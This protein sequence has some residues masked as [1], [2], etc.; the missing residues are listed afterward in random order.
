MDTSLELKQMD[1]ETQK[2]ITLWLE[3]DY[4][5]ET[6]EAIRHLLK[7]NPQE[8]VDAFYKT[9]TFGTG[10]MR[11]IMGV[12]TNRMNLYTIRT[13]TQGLANYILQQEAGEKFHSVFIGYDS[14]HHSKEFAEEAAKVLAANNIH[15]FLYRDLRPT[16]LISF[17]CRFKK[18]TAGIMITA[19]HNTPEYNGYKVYWSDGGQVLPPHDIGIVEEV[20]KILSLSQVHIVDTLESPLINLIEE[21]VDDAYL[22]SI[23]TLQFYPQENKTR[24]QEL[25]IIYTSLHGTGITLV[26]RALRM[27]GF[28]KF[29][30]VDPQ[31]IPDGDFPTAHYP[32]PEEKEALSLG[33]SVLA[34][35]KAD[36]LIATDPDCD[37]VGV[38]VHHQGKEIILTGNQVAC[39]A[40]QH[41]CEA[42][43]Q[44]NKINEKTAF[45]K[46]IVTTELFKRIA[47]SFGTSCF[48][49][50][51]GF[52][53]IAEKIREWDLDKSHEYIFGG[54][55]SYGY[56]LG[57][58]S[59]DKDAVLSSTLICEMALKAKLQGKTC[60]DLLHEL[61]EKHG[62]YL[63]KLLSI[64]F[65][66][67]KEGQE[68]MKQSMALLR[69]AKISSILEFPVVKID[70]YLTSESHDL[71]NGKTEKLQLP[72]SDVLVYWLENTGK[73]MVRP[74][75]TEPKVKIYCEVVHRNFTSIADGEV[76]AAEQ[77][78][79]LLQAVEDLLR[80][81]SKS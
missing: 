70:D 18:C 3:G 35:R 65:E 80:N 53:Y 31:I 21:E 9:L 39:I 68:E 22:E 46:T 48:D 5:D 38:V 64:N 72:R 81:S 33:I 75:G 19:S 52:K 60:V 63:N 42:L 27:W 62:I 8:A 55:E 29:S 28:S 56:L 24:G 30:F 23:V 2:N 66:E 47:E 59:R 40:L 17:G 50:L 16:P 78:S 11:G 10:G 43:Q 1:E 77:A 67:S 26:P 13:A 57:T 25:N 76:E 34:D 12:G 54:E 15:V 73:V 7:E 45:V 61:Y 32:N 4:D 6:K 49:V 79:A 20:R 51:T 71:V 37:R 41:I 69:K 44:Q 74:S 14:R 36:L 58:Y